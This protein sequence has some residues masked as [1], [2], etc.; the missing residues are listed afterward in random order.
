MLN[1]TNKNFSRQTDK[2][3]MCARVLLFVVHCNF[4]FWQ[5]LSLSTVQIYLLCGHILHLMHEISPLGIPIQRP[6]CKRNSETGSR[7]YKFPNPGI[8]ITTNH[9]LETLANRHPATGMLV[10]NFKTRLSGLPKL[11]AKIVAD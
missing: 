4:V 6:I 1:D 9:L 3:F 10:L 7:D 2:I 11:L 8:A 5:S